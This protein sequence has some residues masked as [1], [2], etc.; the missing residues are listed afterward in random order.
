MQAVKVGTTGSL[1]SAEDIKTVD[2]NNDI[3]GYSSS[4]ICQILEKPHCFPTLLA[5][6]L[7]ISG[8]AEFN[9]L[10]MHDYS[11]YLY[12][13][14]NIK[15]SHWVPSP[16]H[17]WSAP[18]DVL[19]MLRASAQFPRLLHWNIQPTLPAQSHLA[20]ITKPFQFL[21]TKDYLMSVK[22]NHA[23]DW[24]YWSKL[25]LILFLLELLLLFSQELKRTL[26][27]FCSEYF[28][29]VFNKALKCTV[30]YLNSFFGKG[31]RLANE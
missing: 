21:C 23:T 24:Q 7:L 27:S 4:S 2:G 17:F 20:F 31:K 15:P 3:W 16:I 29:W 9:T 1:E 12:S 18:Y 22:Q 10:H 19:N 13:F 28:N 14:Y 6:L 8:K 25:S 5:K 30:F 26:N 11:M